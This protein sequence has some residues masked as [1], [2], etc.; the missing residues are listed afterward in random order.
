MKTHI[1]K[2]KNHTGLN[3]NTGKIRPEILSF[4]KSL[5]IFQNVKSSALAL[6]YKHIREIS[7][8]NHE[9]VYQRG[10]VSDNIYI[11]RYGE[12]MLRLGP[13][14]ET[15]RYLGSGDVLSENS[16]LTGSPHSGSAQ[17]LLDTLL[18][19]IN[20]KQFLK[21]AEK[22]PEMMKNLSRLMSS[23]ML[24]YMEGTVSGKSHARRL[25]CHIPLEPIRDFHRH[26]EELVHIQGR[27]FE[28]N[29][30]LINIKTFENLSP[31]ESIIKLS[32]LRHDF[33]VIHLYFSDPVCACTFDQLVIQ[34]DQ[35]V[36]WQTS[37]EVE[38]VNGGYTPLDCRFPGKSCSYCIEEYWS[39]CVRN[40]DDRSV[41]M[42]LNGKSIHKQSYGGKKKM[43]IRMETLARYLISKTRGIALGGGGARALAHVGV[44]KILEEQ[45]IHIDY[46]SGSSFGAVIGALYARGENVSSI[47]RILKKNFGGVQR[48]FFDPTLPVVSFYRGKKMIKMLKNTFGEM[49]I[50]ELQIPF[51]TSAVDLHSGNEIIFDS[52][53]LWEALTACMSL[54]GVFPPLIIGEKALIDG[55][56]LNNVPDSLIRQKGANV[57]VSVNVSPLE[58]SGLVKLLENGNGTS[59]RSLGRLWDNVK[60]PPI[61][62][63]IGRAIS[64]EGRELLRLK[65]Q[66]M[67]FFVSLQLSEYSI[68]DFNKFTEII[69]VGENQF[70]HYLPGVKK[71]FFSPKKGTK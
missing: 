8:S 63:I 38:I 62:K 34:S 51:V 33:P 49:R 65:Q 45:G 69:S 53:L 47:I 39:S 30:K 48:P 64:L 40:F 25:I 68:F 31:S 36:L 14:G 54:P 52:G 18:Y 20:G 58:D 17:A 59:L 61:L 27:S 22:E 46:V 66:N 23:R 15:I 37:P 71:L 55:G 70:K 5:T 19:E 21:I 35:I 13:L 11:L 4:L 2:E 50:E 43:F 9:Y 26:M 32:R 29:I 7:I 16:V 10:D 24:D 44:L 12:V 56:T 57:I 6:L 3:G 28:K 67:D 41:K 60:H 42:V 1:K